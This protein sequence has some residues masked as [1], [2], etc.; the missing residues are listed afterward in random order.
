MATIP[1]LE[2]EDA[3]RPGRERENLVVSAPASATGSRAHL[4]GSASAASSR[5]CGKLR[6]GSSDCARRR[7][8]RCRP[9]PWPSCGARWRACACSPNRSGRSRPRARSVRQRALPRSRIW[10]KHNASSGGTRSARPSSSTIRSARPRPL[11]SMFANGALP[12][13]IP[14]SFQRQASNTQRSHPTGHYFR[15]TSRDQSSSS[16][17]PTGRCGS[18]EV[19]ILRVGRDYRIRG[20]SRVQDNRRGRVMKADH[21][22]ITKRG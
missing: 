3:K 10:R 6:R 11:S 20:A 22:K 8:N 4:R 14:G 12:A 16:L 17:T 21:V 13:K 7:E 1:S 2:E 18:L 19:R 5:P 15:L 9:T